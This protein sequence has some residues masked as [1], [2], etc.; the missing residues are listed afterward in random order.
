MHPFDLF[1]KLSN[2]KFNGNLF[3]FILKGNISIHHLSPF[4]SAFLNI[5]KKYAYL[6]NNFLLVSYIIT[7]AYLKKISFN[8]QFKSCDTSDNHFHNICN[9]CFVLRNVPNSFKNFHSAS[10]NGFKRNTLYK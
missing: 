9:I 2:K 6:Q 7:S 10:K 3:Y 1:F 4:F 5:T 8:L